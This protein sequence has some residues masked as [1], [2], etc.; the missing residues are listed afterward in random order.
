MIRAN[1]RYKGPGKDEEVFV[2]PLST[3]LM[4]SIEQAKQ[5]SN[6]YLS[7]LLESSQDPQPAKLKKLKSDSEE[8]VE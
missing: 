5:L 8:E 2:I 3:S 6:E 1:G 4:D 7:S